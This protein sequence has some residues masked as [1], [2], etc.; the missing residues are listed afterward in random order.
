M[1]FDEIEQALSTIGV[2]LYNLDGTI[3]DFKDVLSDISNVWEKLSINDKSDVAK[4]TMKMGKY[5][6]TK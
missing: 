5:M 2:S 6:Q 1:R 3:R 4:A